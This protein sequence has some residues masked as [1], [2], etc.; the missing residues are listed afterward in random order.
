MKITM[1]EL[2]NLV[3]HLNELTGNPKTTHNFD[4]GSYRSNPGNY[5]IFSAY[6]GHKLEQMLEGGGVLDVLNCGFCTKRILF[7]LI[8]A[9]LAGYK[10]LQKVTEKAKQKAIEKTVQVTVRA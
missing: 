7:D 5:S 2:E 8:H 3:N 9:F 1:I 10:T 6:G 4:S